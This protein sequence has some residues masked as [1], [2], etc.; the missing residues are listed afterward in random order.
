MIVADPAAVALERIDNEIRADRI[1]TA[2]VNALAALDTFIRIYLRNQ[3]TLERFSLLYRWFQDQMQIGSIH[4]A[5]D[6]SD[7]FGQ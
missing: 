4:I 6:R 3:P 1:E 7:R 5:I 2:K